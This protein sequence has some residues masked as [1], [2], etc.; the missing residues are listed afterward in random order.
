MYI[1]LI[2]WIVKACIWCQSIFWRLSFNKTG[3]IQ[4]LV[5][6]SLSSVSGLFMLSL[7]PRNLLAYCV[8][9]TEPKI[10]RLILIMCQCRPRMRPGRKSGLRR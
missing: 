2:H 7:S 6:V 5:Q 10:F 9:Q 8:G 4:G 1:I 3:N